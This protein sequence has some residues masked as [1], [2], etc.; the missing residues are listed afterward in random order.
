VTVW[1]KINFYCK[2][3]VVIQKLQDIQFE[4][5]E[6]IGKGTSDLNGEVSERKF[7]QVES[8]CNGALLET[9]FLI[10][11]ASQE[12]FLEKE[13]Q[14]SHTDILIHIYIY[15]YICV[16]VCLIGMTPVGSD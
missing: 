7:L 11:Y 5:C 3:T 14:V 16:W 1:H 13:H 9:I 4:Y 12:R 15:I 8:N 6:S 2:C 10:F